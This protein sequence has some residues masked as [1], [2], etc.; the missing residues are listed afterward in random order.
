MALLFQKRSLRHLTIAMEWDAHDIVGQLP[1]AV[2]SLHATRLVIRP[3]EVP[4]NLAAL[5]GVLGR[6]Q[7][8]AAHIEVWADTHDI[9]LFVNNLESHGRTQRIQTDHRTPSETSIGTSKPKSLGR[10]LDSR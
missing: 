5:D 1:P 6:L 9:L 8:V 3:M 10:L 7:E 4:V 2:S